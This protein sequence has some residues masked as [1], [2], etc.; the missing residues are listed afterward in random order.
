MASRSAS[1]EGKALGLEA[2]TALALGLLV[3]HDGDAPPIAAGEDHVGGEGAGRLVLQPL[4]R[5]PV[6][7]PRPR[8][9]RPSIIEL[10]VETA[11]TARGGG[12]LRLDA[13][14][15]ATPLHH[16]R[17][18]DEVL[19]VARLGV[20]LADVVEDDV[21]A[22]AALLMAAHHGALEVVVLLAGEAA[23]TGG[24]GEGLYAELTHEARHPLPQ[25][26][27]GLAP[28]PHTPVV[29]LAEAEARGASPVRRVGA[30]L[31]VGA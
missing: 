29:T 13:E 18:V 8:D 17:G 2:Y 9:R 3:P 14:G 15:D 26:L 23:D 27:E 30:A 1:V 16:L 7:D 31:D 19:E 25:D 12:T 10:P 22:Y 21:V 11:H 5:A 24:H 20:L 6:V 4:P 28:V